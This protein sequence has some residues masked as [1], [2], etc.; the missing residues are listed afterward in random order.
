[1][2]SSSWLA[3]PHSDHYLSIFPTCDQSIQLHIA[4][5]IFGSLKYKMDYATEGQKGYTAMFFF[6]SVNKQS[7]TY[8]ANCIHS[9]LAV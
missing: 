9:F 7:V 2:E 1:M 5:C 4:G 3:L 6:L 8:I